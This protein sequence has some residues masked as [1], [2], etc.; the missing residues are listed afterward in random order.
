MR[1]SPAA[2]KLLAAL[3]A[4]LDAVGAR[5]GQPIEWTERE[6]TVLELIA[7]NID[8]KTALDA[9]FSGT[10]D[11]KLRLK[12]SAELRLLEAALARLL[13]QVEPEPPALSQR[14]LKAQRAARARWDRPSA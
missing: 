10:E 5:L 1:H 4:E 14:S 7:S 2:R 3:N 8:R 6:R 9:Q 11:T 13:K 12:L